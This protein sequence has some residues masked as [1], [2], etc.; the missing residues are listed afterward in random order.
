VSSALCSTGQAGQHAHSA[1][2][3]DF[4]A[5]PAIAIEALL[6]AKP[7]HL[8]PSVRVWEPA[9]GLG[10]IA[11]PLRSRGF[12]VIATDIVARGFALHATVDFFSLTAAPAGC[13]VILT[14]PPY[15]SAQKFAEHALDLVPDV[16]LLLRLA[17]LESI[18]R[19]ELLERRGLRAVYVFR[20]RLPMMHRDGWDGPRAA[21]SIAFAWFCWRRGHSGPPT[22]HRI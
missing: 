1:R 11:V 18:R 3:Y 7:E 8:E 6:Q 12:A 21:S 13:S 19:T 9:A 4:Y 2:G 10:G 16:Y 17:F 15:K 20:R 14:N 22:L 5:T